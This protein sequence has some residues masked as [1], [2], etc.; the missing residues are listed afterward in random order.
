[1][2]LFIALLA[3]FRILLAVLALV[4]SPALAAAAPMVWATDGTR[5]YQVDGDSKAL[6]R[7]LTYSGIVARSLS[8]DGSGGVWFADASAIRH[9]GSTGTLGWNGHGVERC[10]QE[11]CNWCAKW[12]GRRRLLACRQIW[13]PRHG[14]F[15]AD[16]R[17]FQC[18]AGTARERQRRELLAEPGR[19]F[20]VDRGRLRL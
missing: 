1:V 14:S 4:L 6:V 19:Q 16:G 11:R 17:R 9:L 2:L 20:R 3:R 13:V 8:A 5:L 7:T 18:W 15:P 12:S 10:W